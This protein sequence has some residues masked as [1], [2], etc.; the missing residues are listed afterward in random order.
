MKKTLLTLVVLLTLGSTAFA[1]HGLEFGI[2]PK[3]G[4]QTSKLSYKKADIQ[5]GFA[6]HFTA[7]LFV[8]LGLAGFYV[9][10]E[11]LWFK[12]SN[13]F[14][15]DFNTM[16]NDNIFHIPTG[17]SVN[18]SMNSQNLQVPLMFGYKVLD[19][20]I[21]NLRVQVGPTMN[22][23]LKSNQ[24]WGYTT[25][26]GSSSVFQE[27]AESL[28]EKLI[29]PKSVSWGMQAGLGVDLFSKLTLDINYNFGLSKV[30]NTFDTA[31]SN[32]FNLSSVDSSKQNLFMV[33]LGV[34]F[35]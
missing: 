26:E 17:A 24:L 6:N 12:T 5:D 8:R 1:G 27:E 13:V 30:F 10:P 18:L 35:P 25:G 33:T 15:F 16:N 2:G 9:Q 32:L 3:I 7:G 4:Y 34:K 14:D 19:L 11:V 23:V 31:G 29:D 22:F 28:A 21:V 20:A